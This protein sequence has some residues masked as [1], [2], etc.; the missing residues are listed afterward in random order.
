MCKQVDNCLYSLN[1]KEADTVSGIATVC[2]GTK[3]ERVTKLLRNVYKAKE[4]LISPPAV[5]HSSGSS[6]S[7]ASQAGPVNLLKTRGPVTEL[8]YA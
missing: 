4:A 8:E 6:P 2:S 7:H 1:D 3:A 5:A